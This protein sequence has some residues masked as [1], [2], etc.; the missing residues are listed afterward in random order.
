[1]PDR[2]S[3]R[4]QLRKQ[5]AQLDPA[6]CKEQSARLCEHLTSTWQYR[7]AQRIACYFAQGKEARLD[8]L[9]NDAWHSGKQVFMPILGLRHHGQ[10]WFVPCEQDTPLYKNRF[11]IDEPMHSPGMRR[12][13]LRSLDLLLIPLVGFDRAGNRLGMGG[14]FYDRTLASI[15]GRHIWSRP[16]RIGIAY[17]FQQVERVPV[18]TWDVPLDAVVT[19]NGLQWF[20]K[21]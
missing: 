10:L 3:L 7:R 8:Y 17:A 9:L 18:E 6:W 21:R 14:G 13:P 1:M 2:Q 12:T 19:E 16:R 11:G 5:R 15:A 20:S 4:A